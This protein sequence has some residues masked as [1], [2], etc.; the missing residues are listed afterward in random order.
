MFFT[1]IG[2][3]MVVGTC[4]FFWYLLP[5][6]GQVNRLV[7]NSDVGSM[8]TIGIMSFLCFGIALLLEGLLG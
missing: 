7:Q 8:V 6:D 4:A 3:V 1:I 5:R 2:A